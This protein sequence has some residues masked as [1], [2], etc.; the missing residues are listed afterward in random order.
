MEFAADGL[1]EDLALNLEA[2]L[3][4]SVEQ[5]EAT[6]IAIAVTRKVRDGWKGQAIYIPGELR[7]KLSRRDAA[8]CEEFTGNNHGDLAHKYSVS[9]VRIRQILDKQIGIG[10]T[11]RGA[12]P[13]SFRKRKSHG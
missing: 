3:S 8:I 5:E 9:T 11:E 13:L 7:Q 6:R 4:Q 2:E 10:R 1:L 12:A